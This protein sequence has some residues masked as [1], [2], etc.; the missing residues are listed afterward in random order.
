M[1]LLVTHEAYSADMCDEKLLCS[2]ITMSRR[3]INILY[4]KF[5]IYKKHWLCEDRYFPHICGKHLIVVH[6]VSP[7]GKNTSAH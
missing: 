1:Y 3:K 4:I 6:I 2:D 5:K 7:T